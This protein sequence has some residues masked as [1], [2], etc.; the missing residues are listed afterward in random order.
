MMIGPREIAQARD[1]A[2]TVY[3]MSS[4]DNVRVMAALTLLVHTVCMSSGS[5]AEAINKM[6]VAGE[7][8]SRMI[9]Q[10]FAGRQSVH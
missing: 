4:D 2:V 6:L 7:G 8:V 10:N 1:L 3:N 5:A 9:E